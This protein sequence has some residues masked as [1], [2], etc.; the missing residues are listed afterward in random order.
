MRKRRSFYGKLALMLVLT[1]TAFAALT[2][3]LAETS[4]ELIAQKKQVDLRIEQLNE[5]I[6]AL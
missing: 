2:P 3:F 4:E 6:T 5:E 1:T